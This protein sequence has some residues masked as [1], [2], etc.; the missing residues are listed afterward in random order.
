[1]VLLEP[2]FYMTKAYQA[3]AVAKVS[4]VNYTSIIYSL[5]FGFILFDES[6]GLM[7]YLGMALVLAG[8]LLSVIFK[9][10]S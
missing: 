6:F 9:N 10:R 7:T 5:S 4:I 8:V 3:E 2:Q 1:M